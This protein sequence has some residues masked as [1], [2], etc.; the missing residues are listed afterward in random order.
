[1]LKKLLKYD[2][3]AVS[4]LF[5]IGAAISPIAAI[6]G[7]LLMR[8]FIASM[9]NDSG[10]GFLVFVALF[11]FI[12]SVVSIL[13]LVLSYIFTVV[14]VF[15]RFYRHFFTDEG[16][17]TFTLPVKRSTLFFSKTLSATIFLTAHFVVIFL[18]FLLFALLVPPAQEGGFFINPI[19][20]TEIGSLFSLLWESVGAWLI[21][22]LLEALLALFLYLLFSILLVQFCITFGA[23]LVKR[24]KIVISLLL[25][26]GITSVL[27]SIGQFAFIFAGSFLAESMSI[28][29]LDRG[30]NTVFAAYAFLFLALIAAIATVAATLYALTQY[31]IDR[32]LNLA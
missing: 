17:L 32:K 28:L 18:S 4:K 10:N 23:I 29:M 30:E 21:L 26:Y 25:Y 13:A 5:W 12:A 9:E 2:M 22:Y 24:A 31:L 6:L 11:A 15:V 7:A 14:L 20:F 16:Y 19:F 27:S 8:F 1:M 3:R